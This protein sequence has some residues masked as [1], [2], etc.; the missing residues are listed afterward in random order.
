MRLLQLRALTG[1]RLTL[2]CRRSYLP[3]ALHQVLQTADCAVTTDF[4]AARR[5][6]C[7]ATAPVS[8]ACR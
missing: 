4:Q 3:A 1:I 6:Y 8:P 7:G 2:V 5:H